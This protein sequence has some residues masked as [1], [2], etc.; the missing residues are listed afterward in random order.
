MGHYLCMCM[1]YIFRTPTIIISITF[2]LLKLAGLLFHS[3]YCPAAHT[4]AHTS[5]STCTH[6]Q[7][8]E[9]VIHLHA[10]TRPHFLHF[11]FFFYMGS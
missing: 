5:T 8:H 3:Y 6:V 9:H 7:K 11:F 1:I 10:H 4:P 2:T